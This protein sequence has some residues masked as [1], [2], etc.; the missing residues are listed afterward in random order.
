MVIICLP[1]CHLSVTDVL[2]LNVF[3]LLH[4]EIKLVILKYGNA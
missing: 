2:W 3:T 1:V 4:I